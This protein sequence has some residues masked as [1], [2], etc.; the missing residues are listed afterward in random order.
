[1]GR[2]SLM[3]A[4][5]AGQ[6]IGALLPTIGQWVAPDE[7]WA[8][9]MSIVGIMLLVCAFSVAM[10]PVLWVWFTEIF[11]PDVNLAAS[12]AL[13][14]CNWITGIVMVF[15]GTVIT[16][17]ILFTLFLVLNVLSFLFM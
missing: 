11:P 15:V 8:Q 5:I 12:S 13:V 3:L 14:A 4:G 2:K 1:M 16:D 9:I 7:S 6:I 17:T 10:G